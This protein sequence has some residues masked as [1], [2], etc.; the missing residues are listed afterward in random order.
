VV[1]V[2]GRVVGPVWRLRRGSSPRESVLE[3]ERKPC[4]GVRV[5][6]AE[7]RA[8]T[9]TKESGRTPTRKKVGAREWR[10]QTDTKVNYWSVHL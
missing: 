2:W 10:A 3:S 1:K 9:D 8:H 6:H 7:W 4:Q 5:R